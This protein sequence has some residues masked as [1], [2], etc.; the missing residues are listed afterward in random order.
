MKDVIKDFIIEKDL[1]RTWKQKIGHTLCLF[2]PIAS[3]F[4]GFFLSPA[5]IA[6]LTGSKLEDGYNPSEASKFAITL[7]FFAIPAIIIFLVS[8]GANPIMK[9]IVKDEKKAAPS[10][11]L[12]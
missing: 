2:I 4:A 11:S 7:V 6:F 8:R 10:D 3:A 5:I 12:E 1:R 9:I